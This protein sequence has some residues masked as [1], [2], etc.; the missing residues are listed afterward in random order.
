MVEQSSA[1]CAALQQAV[2]TLQAEGVEIVRG[3]AV[4]FAAT[5]SAGFD[6]IF[7]DPLQQGSDRGAWS[8]CWQEC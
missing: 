8:R 7:L 1:A 6:V 2:K 4:K 5:T 3:D